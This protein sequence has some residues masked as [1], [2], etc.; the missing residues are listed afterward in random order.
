MDVIATPRLARARRPG[1]SIVRLASLTAASC[2]RQ[3][4]GG[5]GGKARQSQRTTA[6]T[7]MTS[8]LQ[9]QQSG[10]AGCL[11]HFKLGREDLNGCR[12]RR[13]RPQPARRTQSAVCWRTAL[14]QRA[15]AHEEQRSLQRRNSPKR[16]SDCHRSP[17]LDVHRQ[18]PEAAPGRRRPAAPTPTVSAPS[19]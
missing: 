7:R 8:A 9:S 1:S 15:S 19:S 12:G 14:M 18:G 16:L 17:E 3:P 6:R 5:S 11:R 4:S 2:A 10:S 13:R